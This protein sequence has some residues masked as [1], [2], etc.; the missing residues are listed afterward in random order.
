M[1]RPQPQY[2]EMLS[3]LR[4]SYVS[5]GTCQPSLGLSCFFYILNQLRSYHSQWKHCWPLNNFIVSDF[6]RNCRMFSFSTLQALNVNS[7]LI[8]TINNTNL[9]KL[10]KGYKISVKTGEISSRDQW[11]LQLITMYNILESPKSRF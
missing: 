10:V 4:F 2:L 8:V 1:E 5:L 3:R 9:Q 7:T 11:W 6:S